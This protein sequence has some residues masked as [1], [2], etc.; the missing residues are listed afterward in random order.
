MKTAMLALLAILI[1]GGGA[2]GVYFYFFANQAEAAIGD[3]AEHQAAGEAPAAKKGHGDKDKDSAHHAFIELSPLIL[4]IVDENGV[5]QVVSLVVVIEVADEKAAE[6]VKVLQPRLN[7]A[8][9]RELYGVLNKHAAM[10]G[11]VLQVGM[12]KERLVG[13]SGG[14]L[15]EDV[16]EDVLLQ[17][18]QQRPL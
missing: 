17:V 1:L 4:P 12:I 16:V 5:N 10:R 11:G 14:V 3:T 2:G 8:Y 9:I 18:V 6:T 13:I 7:D 15:G